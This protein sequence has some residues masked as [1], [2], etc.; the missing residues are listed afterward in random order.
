[1]ADIWNVPQTEADSSKIHFSSLSFNFLKRNQ[2]CLNLQAQ[3]SI[4]STDLLLFRLKVR[5]SRSSWSWN[6]KSA[7]LSIYDISFAKCGRIR[8][9]GKLASMILRGRSWD[10][11]TH[12]IEINE[13]TKLEVLQASK[14]PRGAPEQ[15]S[16]NRFLDG[17]NTAFIKH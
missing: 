6:R 8:N 2:Y 10:V 15:I 11:I 17:W 13:L 12:W 14:T 4:W 5:R 16:N 1:M 3:A 9:N 7:V